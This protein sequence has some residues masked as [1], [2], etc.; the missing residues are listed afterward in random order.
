MAWGG[1]LNKEGSKYLRL[2]R[3]AD[4]IANYLENLKQYLK[5]EEQLQINRTI[6]IIVNHINDLSE[7][8]IKDL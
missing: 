1:S 7:G 2:V 4:R 5:K 8:K 3:E 6:E